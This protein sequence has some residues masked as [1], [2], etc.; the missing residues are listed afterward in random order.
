M[1]DDLENQDIVPILIRAFSDF[2][3]SADKL[4]DAYRQLVQDSGLMIREESVSRHQP[5]PVLSR[6]LIVALECMING[7][8][9]V[10]EA[11]TIILFNSMAQKLTGLCTERIVGRYYGEVFN[12]NHL[13]NTL[14]TKIPIHSQKRFSSGVKAESYTTAILDNDGNPIG[15]IEELIPQDKGTSG[16]GEKQEG[17][18]PSYIT[19]LIAIIGDI[20]INIAHRMRSPLSAIQLFA[21]LLMQ[22]LDEEKQKIVDDILVGVHS[23]DAVLSNLLSFAQP[24]NPH[25]QKVDIIDILDES[26][27][28]AMPAINQQNI[29]LS[30]I[31]S[32]SRLYCYGDLEQLKQVCFNLIL[33]AIQAMPDGG[34]LSISAS[35]SDDTGLVSIEIGDNG[36]GIAD[37]HMDRIF[38][39]FFTTKEGGAGL[40]LYVVYKLIEAHRGKIKINST[41]G[42]GTFVSVQ[43]PAET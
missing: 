8:I 19:K 23:V 18:V 38:A 40:G 31:H 6:L 41:Y 26:L 30:R 22:D 43:L 20:I 7:V 15:A 13:M 11:G 9:I 27:L 33:N 2:S 16:N 37:E 28:F 12:E 14:K 25:F 42:R 5:L 39:P 29:K 36:C 3:R 24:A 17:E 35:Y 10:D 1:P 34:I 4:S 32:H 21:E